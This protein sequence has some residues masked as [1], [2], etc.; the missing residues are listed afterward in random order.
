MGCVQSGTCKPPFS[1]TIT[2]LELNASID[3][4]PTTVDES[5]DVVLRYRTPY[6]RASA[7][8]L[9]PPVLK[10]EI[11]TIGWIQACNQM[12]FYNHYGNEGLSSWELPALRSGRVSALSDSDGV[13]YPWYGSTSELY[14]VVGPTRRET[15]LTVSMNDNFHPSVT[16]S[17]PIATVGSPAQLTGIRRH[18]RFTTWLVA[19]HEASGEITLLRTL[20]W[21]VRLRI[22]VDPQRPLGQRARLLEPLLQDQPL[23][24]PSNEPLP[25]SALTPPNANHAQMLMWR[26]SNAPPI[27]VIPPRYTHTH[28]P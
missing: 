19:R 16:W 27:M 11:W 7:Q 6:F 23:V 17:V 4:N 14:T 2:V 21:K 15:R 28:T 5:S 24:L 26:P 8:V 3:P 18:Q 20:R 13:S 22:D 1:D 12:D 25:P 10:K 9:V